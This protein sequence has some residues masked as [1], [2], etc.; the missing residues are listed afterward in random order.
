MTKIYECIEPAGLVGLAKL[1]SHMIKSDL[2]TLVN[3]LQQTILN[4]KALADSLNLIGTEGSSAYKP[5]G[6]PLKFYNNHVTKFMKATPKILDWILTV[7]QK[8]IIRQYIAFE[9]NSN[10]KFYSKNFESS[11]RTM[12]E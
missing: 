1:Y 8:Q 11:L 3:S 2:E 6:Q 10:C 7:G 4:D 9:L 5:I 12:N